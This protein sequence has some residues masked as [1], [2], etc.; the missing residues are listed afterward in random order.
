MTLPSTDLVAAGLAWHYATFSDDP[1]FAG[2]QRAAQAAGVGLWA[3]RQPVPP[4]EWRATEQEQ[5][6]QPA[7][8]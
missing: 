4:W 5:K 1:Q 6:R 3:D 7:T 8:R 2:A